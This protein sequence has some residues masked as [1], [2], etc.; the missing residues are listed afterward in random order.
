M[1]D[2]KIKKGLDLPISGKPEGNVKS[3][4]LGGEATPQVKPKKIALNLD[5][6]D[7]VRFKLLAK[8]G[9]I[10]TIGQPLLE[11][12]STAGRLFA[13]PAGGVISEVRRG[14]K[15]RLLDI[16]IDVADE[17]KRHSVG[18]T[19]LQ[20]VTREALL[21]KLLEGGLFAHIRSRPFNILADPQKPPRSIFVKAIESAPFT[22][23]AELQIEGHEEDF[24]LGLDALAK[25][26]DGKVHLV[27]SKETSYKPF[28]GAKN[29]EKHTASGPHPAGN[30]SLH[31]HKIDPIGKAD[32]VSWTL[33]ALDAAILGHL[34]RTGHYLTERVVSIAGPGIIQGRTG[35]FK[36]RAGYPIE[37]LL[38]NRLKSGLIRLISG[39]PYTGRKVQGDDFLGFYD[40]AFC[41]IPENV[42]REFL[43]F[44][45]LGLNK[46][47]FSGAYF[48]GH[49]DNADK[50]Y[51]FT[52]SLHGEPRALIEPSLYDKV[53]P[54]PVPTMQLVKA[55][56]AEDYDL[57]EEL[58]LLEV[59]SEDFALPTFVCPSKVEMTEI[60]K[61]GLRA[62]AADV[63]G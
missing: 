59:D 55:V 47:S 21:K 60:I 61:T 51:D 56:M 11:D 36:V 3:L 1:A 53:M 57:A 44:F 63:L 34:L 20:S 6:F 18:T 50:E 26:T 17:E 27:Y 2:I 5:P 52:T 15:R 49:V 9:D 58:G 54:L 12:K 7:D 10:V 62:H 41:A 24:Q 28:L 14:L 22:P 43:H 8:K 33:T 42:K 37:A 19:D 32:D 40:T 29:V 16:V 31:I 46:F 38:S 25:L 13:S 4:T 48:S 23:P 45:R 35:Y 39:N 30:F